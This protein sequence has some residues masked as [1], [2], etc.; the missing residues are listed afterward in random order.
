MKGATDGGIV[1]PHRDNGKQFPGFYIDEESKEEAFEPEICRKYIFGGHVGDY[2]RKLEE[3]N[4]DKYKKQFSQYISK[5]IT[6]DGLEDMYA[7]VHAAIRANPA[8]LPKADRK[9]EVSK[10]QNKKKISAAL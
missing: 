5:G 4:E 8:A 2:M 1:I 10:Y 9:V 6:A 3:D 7:K